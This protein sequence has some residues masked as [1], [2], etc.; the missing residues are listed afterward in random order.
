MIVFDLHCEHG[1]RF[2]GWFKSSSAFE[3]QKARGLVSCAEC[4]TSAVSKAPMA[5]AVPAKSNTKPDSGPE[6]T[7]QQ[8]VQ[9]QPVQA[10]EAGKEQAVSN[11]PPPAEVQKAIEALAKAQAK[12]LENSTYVGK[13][14]V[15][16]ARE[17]HYGERDVAPI[18]GQAS[19]EEAREL[20]EEGV[21]VA[22]LPL[23][24]APPDK[25]N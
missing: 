19:L 23:P 12:A 4:G 22:P 17:M 1:H 5:P 11:A 13:D 3:D 15:K 16:E 2:E 6:R 20:V 21:A 9:P 18:H 25:L 7:R 8:Q 24:I 14:F 10:S